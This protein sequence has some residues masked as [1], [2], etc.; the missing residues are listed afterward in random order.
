MTGLM[1]GTRNVG[2][3]RPVPVGGLWPRSAHA[4]GRLRALSPAT[5]NEYTKRIYRHFRLTS[6]A[7]FLAR[8]IR[9][10]WGIGNWSPP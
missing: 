6:R 1:G 10:R 3:V 7:E 8:W 5:V 2:P 4:G 9:R